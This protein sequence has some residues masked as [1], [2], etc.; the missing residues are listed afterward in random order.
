[1]GSSTAW[2]L[3]RAWLS[4][5]EQVSYSL[6]VASA[7]GAGSSLLGGAVWSLAGSEGSAVPSVSTGTS[8]PVG[9]GA[10]VCGVL[11]RGTSAEGVLGAGDA[12][13]VV[14]GAEGCGVA[15]FGSGVGVAWDSFGCQP[16]DSSLCEDPLD[17]PQ[18]TSG[19]VRIFTGLPSAYLRRYASGSTCTLL[20]STSR[21]RCGPV[22]APVLP[23]RPI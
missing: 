7:D 19:S 21:C 16:S 4:V 10:S 5:N 18:L 15:G 17:C 13:S 2:L 6:D 11:S 3:K 8:S 12:G 22:D 20:T 9:S 23:R 14:S 1:M